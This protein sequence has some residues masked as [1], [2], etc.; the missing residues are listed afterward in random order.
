MYW[1]YN[2]VFYFVLVI[3]VWGSKTASTFLNSILFDGKLNLVGVFERSK[4]FK[5]GKTTRQ[6]NSGERR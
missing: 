1:F 3:T 6:L 5:P 2:Y 4:V